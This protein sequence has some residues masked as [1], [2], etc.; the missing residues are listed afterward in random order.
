ML[1]CVSGRRC[2]ESHWASDRR[3]ALP[4]SVV[5]H[6]RWRSSVTRSSVSPV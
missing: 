4:R 2:W 1:R 5:R 3:T 6:T